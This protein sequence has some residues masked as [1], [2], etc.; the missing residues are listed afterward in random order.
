MKN[1]YIYYLL[2]ILLYIHT[3]VMGQTTIIEGIVTDSLTKEPLPFVNVAF[4]NSNVGTTTDFDGK[5]SLKTSKQLN[6]VT[7]SYV[8]YKTV[9]KKIVLGKKQVLKI[10]L[11]PKAIGL[12]E[13][14]I[15]AGKNNYK[16]KDNPAVR[17]IKQVINNKE[18]NRIEAIDFYEYEQYEKIQFAISN[19]T[20]QYKSK[21]MFKKFQ[22]VFENVDTT[23]LEGKP[24]LPFYLYEQITDIYYRQSPK[25]KKEVVKANKAVSFYGMDNSGI[26]QYLQYLYQ[27]INI[28]D[29]NITMLTNQFLSPI[30]NLAPTF[31]RFY[32]VDTMMINSSQYIELAFFP[33]NKYDLLFQGSLFITTDGSYAVQKVEM[34]VNEEIN[35]N[36]VKQLSIRQEFEKYG[37]TGYLLIK[38]EFSADFGLTDN[39]KRGIYGQRV[40]SRK[41]YILNKF[42]DDN[43][44]QNEIES[45]TD[46]SVEKS[47]EY[48]EE[49]RHEV[50]SKS[51]K[52]TYLVMDSI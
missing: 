51:E 5:F 14:E 10:R 41:D 49:N 42:Q 16:N 33:R 26:D 48:W 23:K 15:K 31:Y 13:V 24:V 2:F 3:N 44:Y 39:S 25:T 47:K 4:T 8:G 46:S 19:V 37:E 11:S 17:L 7:F 50:L 30:S 35:L 12:A 28:Y 29:N 32:I 18:E 9:N 34:T 45:K 27:D 21:K 52:G 43:F 20:E 22:F 40:I 1:N 36:W 38:D 6:E